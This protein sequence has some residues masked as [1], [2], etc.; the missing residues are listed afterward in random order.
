MTRASGKALAALGVAAAAHAA[1]ALTALLGVRVR[2]FPRL[3]GIGDAN[4]VALTFDDGP[5]PASTPRFVELLAARGVRATFFLLGSMLARSPRL[6]RDMV[7][8]GQELAVHGWAHDNLLLCGPSTTYHD[9]AAA[10]SLIA[11]ATSQVPRFFRPPYGVLTTPALLAARRLDLEPVLWTC[12]GEDWTPTATPQSIVEKV[13]GGLGGGGTILLH[14]CDFLTV[15]GA[16]R[17]SLA[18]LPPLLDECARRGFAVGPLREH[19]SP[20]QHAET[21][22]S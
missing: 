17:S 12:W 22:R 14:D 3:A 21:P 9:L 16:W 4:R 11:D 5:D 13:R 1:P 18:A 15:P 19:W 2:L 20:R 6:G 8:A 10:R 7:A